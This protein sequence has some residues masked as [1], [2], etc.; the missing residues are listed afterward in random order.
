[1]K[2]FDP[3]NVGWFLVP[4]SYVIDRDIVVYKRVI[5]IKKKSKETKNEAK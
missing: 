3:V 2:T 4:N 1:V 5:K